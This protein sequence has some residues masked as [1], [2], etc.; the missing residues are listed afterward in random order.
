LL[1]EN[2]GGEGDA[3]NLFPITGN[4]NSQHLRSTESPI[5]KW[6]KEKEHWVLYQVRVDNV[7]SQLDAPP[8]SPKNY[9]NCVFV[10][11][12]VQKDAAGVIKN[13]LAT[14]ITSKY[15]SK[16]K[17]DIEVAPPA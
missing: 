2:L 5:K 1:N 7:S 14:Q 13:E 11:K 12:A 8:K 3:D 4:A 15:E 6:V 16:E 17:A 9:V 10:C